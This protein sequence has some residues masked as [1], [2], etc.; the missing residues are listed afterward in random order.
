MLPSSSGL[1]HHP[2]KVAA[3]VQIPLGVPTKKLA[4]TTLFF[5]VISCGGNDSTSDSSADS[6]FIA[7]TG[8]AGELAKVVCEPLSSLWQKSPSE[9]KESWQRKRDDKQ[10]DFDIYVSEKEKQRVSDEALA[11]LGITGSDQPGPTRRSRVAPNGQWASPTSR[12]AIH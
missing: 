8:V 10:V 2:L 11:L 7:P 12:L 9:N 4:L 3:R 1:G 6:D 5:V